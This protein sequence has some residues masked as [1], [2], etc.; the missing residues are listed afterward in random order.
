MSDTQFIGQF[1]S[2]ENTE[3]CLLLTKVGRRKRKTAVRVAA[4]VI[5][6]TREVFLLIRGHIEYK[7]NIGK[8]IR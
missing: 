3:V 6:R 7:L 8:G 1:F 2:V 5:R 4:V